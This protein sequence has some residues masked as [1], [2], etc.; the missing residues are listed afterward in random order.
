MASNLSGKL[1]RGRQRQQYIYRQI[2]DR[3]RAD[4]VKGKYPPS[5]RLP[6]MD[7]L[8][9]LYQVNKITVRRSLA[10]LRNS[11]LIYSVP[12]QGTF[13]ADPGSK[14]AARSK[15]QL[16]TIG[17]LGKVL[18]PSGFGP[19]HLEVMSGI[20]AELGKNHAALVILP[21]GHLSR[22]EDYFKMIQQ[23]HV[24]AIIYLGQFPQPILRHLISQG[25]PAVVVDLPASPANADVVVFDNRA[26]ARKAALHLADLGHR[27][28]ALITGPEEQVAS[29]E[30]EEAA[31][32]AWAERGIL[33]NSVQR[34]VGDF[35]RAS[36]RAA[37]ERILK[38]EVHPTGIF[39][40]NDEMA[41]GALEQ[42]RA[43]ERYRV[44]QNISVIGFDDVF[45]A[46]SCVPGLTTIRVDK[47]LLGRIT[48]QR[49]LERLQEPN[50]AATTTTV[51]PQLMVRNSTAPLIASQV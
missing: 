3:V 44:P 23:A 32:Q 18:M 40:F 22:E 33:A 42:I 5:S 43:D 36:G 31:L 6:S 14:P 15:N 13:V 17:L 12:A 2:S 47:G 27:R 30:R 28:L 29:G 41:I 1:E 38:Q 50:L 21:A 34:Q 26:G 39:A 10:E 8:A 9:L 45:W 24:D 35:T 4:I 11:G 37:M 51:E 49:I 46:G 48:V 25:P 20:Q 16:L 7:D 19:Y